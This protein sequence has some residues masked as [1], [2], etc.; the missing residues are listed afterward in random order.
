MLSAALAVVTN[1]A[2]MRK[3][4]TLGFMSRIVFMVER[5]A[6]GTLPLVMVLQIDENDAISFGRLFFSGWFFEAVAHAVDRFDP[7][8]LIGI[9]F[10]LG[11][12]ACDVIVHG[13]GGRERCVAP[14]DVKELLSCDRASIGLE[15]D[16]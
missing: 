8:R 11:P 2:R 14:D 9:G 10:E 6:D 12:Q 15:Q 13:P 1:K 4:R 5:L 3:R 7:E 16:A